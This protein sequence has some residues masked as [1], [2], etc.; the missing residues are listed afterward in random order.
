M[1]NAFLEVSKPT[2]QGWKR[3]FS[4]LCGRQSVVLL[5]DRSSITLSRGSRVSAQNLLS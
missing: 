5:Q 1:T 4:I 3:S 2:E